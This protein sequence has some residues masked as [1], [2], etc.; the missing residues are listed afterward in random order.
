MINPLAQIDNTYNNYNFKQ[1][2]GNFG[3]DYTLL[4]ILLSLVIW[5]SS[6]PIVNQNLLLKLLTMVEERCLISP[7]VLSQNAI[8]D[9]ITLSISLQRTTKPYPMI[10]K[11]LLWLEIPSIKNTAM[12]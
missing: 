3:L 5:D 9:I 10:I 2:S 6:P 4:K 1:I 8:N 12:G 11:L 7:E